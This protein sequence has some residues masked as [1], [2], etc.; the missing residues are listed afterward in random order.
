[1]TGAI[2]A[3]LGSL[4]N[5]ERLVLHNNRLTGAI[6][7]ALGSLTSLLHLFL[8]NNEL[9][10]EI[11]ATL[12]S[13][14]S[15]T[16]LVLH[17]NRLTGEIPATLARFESTINPQQGGVDLPVASTPTPVPALPLSGVLLLGLLL[18]LLGAVLM[19][20]RTDIARGY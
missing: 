8:Y 2:P 6:P 13:L 17:N 9:T 19:R 16:D 5:L 14:T 3:A 20:M 7:A 15:L 10:G 18:T 11:P 12:G 4:T 1:M